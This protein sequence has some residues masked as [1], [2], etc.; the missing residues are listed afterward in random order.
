[1]SI[2][3]TMPK[4]KGK[5]KGKGNGNGNGKDNGKDKRDNTSTSNS[6]EREVLQMENDRV[7]AQ[8]KKKQQ[9]QEMREQ[10]HGFDDRS[11]VVAEVVRGIWNARSDI[12]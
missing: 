5:G 12:Y 7:A 10:T 8:L 3:T 6:Y 11:R 4:K 9:T 2:T 1:M